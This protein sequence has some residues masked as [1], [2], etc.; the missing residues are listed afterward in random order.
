MT[1]TAL[2]MIP[3]SRCGELMPELR[4]TRFGYE[5]CVNCSSEK[6]KVGKI[7]T[8]GEGDHTWNEIE[9]LDS[10]L[11]SKLTTLQKSETLIN[12]LDFIEDDDEIFDTIQR[13]VKTYL[14][15]EEGEESYQE[16]DEEEEEEEDLEYEE[17]LDLVPYIYCEEEEE[18]V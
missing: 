6:P 13:T 12:D 7:T 3:C 8:K 11:A 1:E 5:V 9:I 14:S 18:E 17:E 16:E 2:K 10:S 4:L 15:L